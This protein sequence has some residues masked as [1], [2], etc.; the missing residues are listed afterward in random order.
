MSITVGAGAVGV[1][2]AG[3]MRANGVPHYPDPNAQGVI[4]I[5]SSPSLNPNSP[6]FQRAEAA[7]E[8]LIPAGKG[9]SPAQ[10]QRHK[11]QALAFA[12]CMRSHGVPNYPDPTFGRGGMISQ[13]LSR[14]AGDPNSPIF[15]ATQK[16]CQTN[17][18]QPLGRSART[19]ERTKGAR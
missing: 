17:G 9:P 3:C 2:Y 12:A 14:S 18:P 4:T 6:L 7:C 5:T 11:E 16:A 10:Q 19:V 1:K 8:Q 15:Q 13:R